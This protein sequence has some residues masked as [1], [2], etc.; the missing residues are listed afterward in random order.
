MWRIRTNQELWEP[1]KDLDIVTDFKKSGMDRTSSN[2]ESCKDKCKVHSRT[3]HEGQR[4]EEIWFYCFFNLGDRAGW[5]EC[6]CTQ[7]NHG[8][9]V[10]KIFESKPEV[11][12]RKGRPGFRWLEDAEND[13]R[14]MKFKRWRQK[15]VDREKQ[16]S[17]I[18]KAR[19]V[20]GQERQGI[21]KTF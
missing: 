21:R 12:R 6:P 9:V 5:V 8:R 1:N 15:A 19:A 17:A 18:K 20:R 16:A 14:E 7:Y 10:K 4:G 2:H 13:L 3:G 11:K